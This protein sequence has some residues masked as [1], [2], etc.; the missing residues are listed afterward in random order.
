L[1]S[2]HQFCPWLGTEEDRKTRY[3]EPIEVHLCYARKV[4]AAVDVDHQAQYCLSEAHRDCA[5]YLEPPPA[6]PP[7]PLIPSEDEVGPPPPR[8]SLLQALLWGLAIVVAAAVIYYY[9]SAL[10][11]PPPAA[12]AWDAASPTPSPTASVTPSPTPARAQDASTPVPGLDRPSAT[13]T[14]YPDGVI[15]TLSPQAGAAGWVA[16]DESRGNHLGDSYMYAGT[17]GG[18]TYHGIFQLDLRVV[19]RGA[20]IHS[21]VLELTGLDA[22][23]LG[24]GGT[25]EVRILARDADADWSR[26]TFQDVHN[27]AVQWSLTPAMTAGELAAGETRAF[28]LSPDVLRDLEQRLLDEHY[29]VSVR[30]DGPLAGEDSLFAWDSGSGPSSN[31]YGPRLVL[32]TGPAPRTPIPTGP[33]PP[34]HTPTPSA[35]PTATETPEW[36]VVTSTPTP[37]NAMTAAAVALRAT[38]L[39]TTTG[40]PTP[41]PPYVATATPDYVVVTRTPTPANQATAVY[42]RGLATANVILTGTPTPPPP[43]LVTATFTPWPTRTPP[44]HWLDELAG[45]TTPTPTPTPTTPPIPAG[46]AGKIL[47]LSDRGEQGA[48]YMLDP[49]SGRVALLTA[50]WPYDVAMQRESLS[51]DGLSRAYVQND[52]RNVPQVYVHSTYYGS[53]WQVT[54]NTR[55]SYDP[56]WS[57]AGDRLAFVSAEGGNDELYVI[58]SD[59]NGQQRLTFNQWEWDKHPSWSPDGQQ[60][61]FWSNEGSGRRQLWMINADGSGRRTLLESEYNDWDPVWVKP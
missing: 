46:L 1:T 49:G 9:G 56:V 36:F 8:F 34:T 43:N 47:F 45:T 61:V 14:P 55:M 28:A 16:G 52:G 21:G 20:T 22:Q 19:P 54:Y 48:V 7:P 23:R 42:L 60:I 18:V 57:P 53:S 5:N 29:T 2:D 13:P 38:A 11:G 3:A 35:T 4:P 27:A 40:T 12:T 25:W 17:F 15:Y 33:L 51:P 39:A 26:G 10:L 6:E 32:N 50:R 31:G 24:S 37:E 59:G 44:Y 30:I 58:G 41:L